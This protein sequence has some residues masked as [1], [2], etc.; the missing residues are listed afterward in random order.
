MYMYEYIRETTNGMEFPLAGNNSDKETVLVCDGYSD[1]THYYR[2]DTMQSN[3]WVRVN[4]W[5]DDGSSEEWY[6]R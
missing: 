4:I 3:G 2:T 1:G 5:Y 6:E